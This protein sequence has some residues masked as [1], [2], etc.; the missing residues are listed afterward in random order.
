MNGRTEVLNKSQLASVMYSSVSQAMRNFGNPTSPS[1]F[2]VN[3]NGYTPYGGN[4]GSRSNSDALIM[5]QNRLL[6]EQNVLLQQIA[7]KDSSI[8]VTDIFSA[9]QAE[10]N[11]YM[12]RTGNSAFF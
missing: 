2:A 11:N 3:S 7:N 1:S 9:I 4:T 10:N 12:N 8:S 6:S 5:E